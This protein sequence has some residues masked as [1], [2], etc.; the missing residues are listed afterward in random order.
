M[1]SNELPAYETWDDWEPIVDACLE[2]IR[3]L[4]FDVEIIQIKEKF[5][6]LRIYFRVDI[7]GEFTDENFRYTDENMDEKIRNEEIVH[8]IIRRYEK[9]IAEHVKHGS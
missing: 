5:N 2:E 6:G 3:Q 1:I 4:P 9:I 7:P 8:K